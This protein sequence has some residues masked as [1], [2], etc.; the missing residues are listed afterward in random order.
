MHV[1]EPR[2]DDRLHAGVDDLAFCGALEPFSDLLDSVRRS[3][4]SRIAGRQARGPS[5]RSSRHGIRI[6]E[7][8]VVTTSPAL[9]LSRAGKCQRVPAPRSLVAVSGLLAPWV[10]PPA[11]ASAPRCPANL[12]RD[13]HDREAGGRQRVEVDQP[14]DLRVRRGRTGVRPRRSRARRARSPPGPA[15]AAAGPSPRRRCP[16]R[17]R[18]GRTAS[19]SPRRSRPGPC[20][21]VVGLAVEVV[22]TGADEDDV[23][24]PPGRGRCV[25]SSASRSCG[26]DRVAV[27]LARHVEHDARAQGTSRAAARR[28]S[29]PRAP[30]IWRVVVPRRVDVGRVVRAEV[31]SKRSVAGPFAV[32]HQVLGHAEER[33]SSRARR[34][35]GRHRRCRCAATAGPAVG[36]SRSSP[37]GPRPGPRPQGPR[38]AAGRARAMSLGCLH[39][40]RRAY[41]CRE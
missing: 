35:R 40:R 34:R 7:V 23:A 2:D 37:R 10:R 27:G 6:F 36:S 31:A 25:R 33:R 12:E 19:G 3:G 39:E 41:R 24:R 32:A 4:S 15:S 5:S 9:S 1:D 38:R 21:T 26:V 8:T 22:A 16:S 28:S 18:R 30:S 11:P 13:A 29:A 14:L 17:A 20:A